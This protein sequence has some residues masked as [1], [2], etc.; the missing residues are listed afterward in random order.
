MLIVK[1]LRESAVILK[2]PGKIN[3][4]LLVLAKQVLMDAKKYDYKMSQYSVD[5]DKKSMS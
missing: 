1:L 3:E 5:T 4:A 2:I